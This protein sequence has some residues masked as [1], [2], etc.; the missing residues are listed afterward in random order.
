MDLSIFLTPL[1]NRFSSSSEWKKNSFGSTIKQYSNEINLFEFD[2]AVIGVLEG[3]GADY[4]VDF[5]EASKKVRE[6]FYALYSHFPKLRIIDLGDVLPG[7]NVTDSYFALSSIIKELVKKEVVPIVI[8]GSQDL[9]Y[10]SYLAY[11]DLEQSVNIVTI[12]PKIDIGIVE[13]EV[14][15]SNYINHILMHQPNYLFN[16]SSVGYQSYYV[17]DELISLMDKLNFDAYRLGVVKSNLEDIE[18][19]VRNADLV[20]FDVSSIKASVAPGSFLS[21]PNGFDG[22]DACRISRYAGLSDKLSMFGL[23]NFFPQQDVYGITA[24]LLAQMIWYFIDGFNNRLGDYPVASKDSYVKYHV[25]IEKEGLDLLFYKSPKSG[26]WWIEVPYPQN[27]SSKHLRHM[28]MPC[29]YEDYLK[30]SEGELPERWWQ[31]YQKII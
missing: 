26:R 27:G 7:E 28:V 18:P 22:E 1:S 10:A 14:S 3:R 15:E 5:K 11:E 20:S 30:A 31:A 4:R 24:K 6:E 19:I 16:Y 9:T 2:I 8:G 29:S 25:A 21:S 17:N 13:D 12:D 23:F